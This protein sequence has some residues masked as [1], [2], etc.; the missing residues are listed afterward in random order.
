MHDDGYPVPPGASIYELVWIKLDDVTD[1][2][3]S[4]QTDDRTVGRGLGL[5]TALAIF[6]NPYNPDPKAIRKEAKRRWAERKDD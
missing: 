6:T 1:A 3:M 4:G 5:A 2:I